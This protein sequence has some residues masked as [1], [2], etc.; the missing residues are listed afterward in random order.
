MG[1]ALIE[2]RHGPVVGGCVTQANGTAE[3]RAAEML[4]VRRKRRRYGRITLGA[5]KAYDTADHVA[6]LRDLGVTPHVAQ[7]QA[8]AK[9]GKTRKSAIDARTTR[10]PGYR[11]SEIRRKAIACVSGFGK[12]HGT[13]R[14]AKL[15]GSARVASV[16]DINLL[17]YN[18][19]RLP[20][21]PAA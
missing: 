10:H 17:A 3:R 4:I 2:N 8:K 7:N 9:T 13:L 18:L 21:L 19:A 20:K 15:T 5:D 6:D 11:A 12:Q 1:H 14:M 16:F